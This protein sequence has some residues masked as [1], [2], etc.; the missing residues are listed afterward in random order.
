MVVTNAAE[1]TFPEQHF[2]THFHHNAHLTAYMAFFLQ[3][4]RISHSLQNLELETSILNPGNLYKLD[5]SSGKSLPFT[6]AGNS[7]VL[8]DGEAMIHRNITLVESFP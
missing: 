3:L 1:A 2:S 6:S 4:E 5:T 8:L 7:C